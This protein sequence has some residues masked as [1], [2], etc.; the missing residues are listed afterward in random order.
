M[1]DHSLIARVQHLS[2]GQ[3]CHVLANALHVY[4]ACAEIVDMYGDTGGMV[5]K[6]DD[7]E[8]K[9][10]LFCNTGNARPLKSLVYSL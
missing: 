7:Y 8:A 4:M 1:I 5:K 6:R 2:N 3:N 10:R 9:L